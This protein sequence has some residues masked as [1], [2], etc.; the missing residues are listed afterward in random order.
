M[1]KFGKDNQSIN[2]LTKIVSTKFLVQN[3]QADEPNW[4]ELWIWSK[5]LF[6][7]WLFA[8]AGLFC[9]MKVFGKR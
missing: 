3:T 2:F 4:S 6:C 8:G 5:S 9:W 7:F 1:Q